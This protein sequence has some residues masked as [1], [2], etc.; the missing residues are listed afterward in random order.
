MEKN[1]NHLKKFIDESS[2]TDGV[3]YLGHASI[4]VALDKKKILFDPIVLSSPYEGSWTFFPSQTQ[5]ES[6]FN[7]D[8]VVVSH[9]YDIEF[10][11]RICEKIPVY[12]I[13]NRPSFESDLKNND[14]KFNIIEPNKKTEL[15]KNIFIYGVVHDYNEIDAST[16]IYT[17]NFS[18]YHGNDNYLSQNLLKKF[19]NLTKKIDVACIPYAYIHWYPFLLDHEIDLSFNKDSEATRLVN[20]YM[21][22]LIEATKILNP[23]IV[24]P[25]GANLIL[26]DGDAYSIM[27]MAVKTPFELYNYCKEK[28]NSIISKIYPLTSNDYILKNE[29]LI[30]KINTKYDPDTYRNEADKYLKNRSKNKVKSLK[31][32]ID[33]DVFLKKLN[34]KIVKININFE[35]LIQI[36][37]TYKNTKINFEIDCLRKKAEIVDFFSDQNPFHRYKL[38]PEASVL[39]L[40]GLRLEEI[41]GMRKF[42]LKRSPNIFMPDILKITMTI[43]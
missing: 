42:T 21:D 14:I 8:A 7:I 18:V 37:T 9:N 35:H 1:I 34:E 36:E 20:K 3:F 30:I 11:K 19:I 13:G 12:I 25:F 28:S 16:L 24:I 5:D 41:I 27:N 10:L 39:W 43:I 38:D 31:L 2:A 33:I 40:E 29:K 26:D 23:D 22:F 6:L 32:D 17:N 15:F 4:L